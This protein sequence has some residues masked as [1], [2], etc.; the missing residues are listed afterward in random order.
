MLQDALHDDERLKELARTPLTLAICI[1][2]H[3][4]RRRLP[5]DRAV[6]LR[7]LADVLERHPG[8]RRVSF[9]LRVNGDGPPLRVRTATARRIR[10]SD[11][12]VRD[13]EAL[14]G[15]GSVLLK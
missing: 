5:A 7:R 1:L 6:V 2:A 15:A 3:A 13:V 11:T 8:D 12:F 4:E 14:C 10:P 9:I